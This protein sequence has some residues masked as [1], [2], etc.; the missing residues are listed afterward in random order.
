MR[1]KRENERMRNEETSGGRRV[2]RRRPPRVGRRPPAVCGGA[3]VCL[4]HTK[5][6][7][8]QKPPIC[9]AAPRAG[10][11]GG[12]PAFYGRMPRIR[13][14]PPQKP[15]LRLPPV[16]APAKAPLPQ[17]GLSLRLKEKRACRAAAAELAPADAF[18]P[19]ARAARPAA[20]HRDGLLRG[21]FPSG[22]ASA[23]L[24][25]RLMRP[26]ALSAPICGICVGRAARLIP[27]A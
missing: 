14:K 26:T 13:I 19:P 15:R 8:K 18:R 21:G 9:A 11:N 22:R 25:V 5:I 6:P 23:S 7:A 10:K 3:V 27:R 1:K 2:G 20:A 4:A 16:F 17:C 12:A 24:S